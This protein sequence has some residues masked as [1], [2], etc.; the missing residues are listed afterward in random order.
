MKT[1]SYSAAIFC[2][3]KGYDGKTVG[4]QPLRTNTYDLGG[5]RSRALRKERRAIFS[6]WAPAHGRYSAGARRTPAVY[7]EA[8]RIYKRPYP[9]PIY[10]YII[11]VYI[12]TYRIHSYRLN[13]NSAQFVSAR[14]FYLYRHFLPYKSAFFK[15]QLNIECP[16]PSSLPA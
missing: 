8:F 1:G 7:G 4:I 12:H 3:Y 5:Y 16:A 6:P 11:Y 2:K 14:C 15:Q 13:K 9:A 10:L